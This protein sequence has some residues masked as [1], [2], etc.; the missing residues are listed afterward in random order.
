MASFRFSTVPFSC[1][2][3]TEKRCFSK[4]TRNFILKLSFSFHTLLALRH[5]E[6]GTSCN[7]HGYHFRNWERTETGCKLQGYNFFI[8]LT[9]RYLTEG[10]IEQV[11]RFF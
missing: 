8:L 3:S 9:F 1:S 2:T 4:R 5:F 7:Q 10:T 11:T 6:S